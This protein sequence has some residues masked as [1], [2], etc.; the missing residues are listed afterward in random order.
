MYSIL[1]TCDELNF[2]VLF[3]ILFLFSFLF[4]WIPE[5]YC[6]NLVK[7]ESKFRIGEPSEPHVSLL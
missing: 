1:E 4:R 7:R 2:F 6:V 5:L 3:R